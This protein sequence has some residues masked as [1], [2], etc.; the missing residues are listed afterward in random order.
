VALDL[1]AQWTV[2]DDGFRSRSV[3][4]WSLGQTL[5]GRVVRTI[6]DGREVFA[7]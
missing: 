1:D 6:A 4:S 3:N 7:A 5:T 2:G